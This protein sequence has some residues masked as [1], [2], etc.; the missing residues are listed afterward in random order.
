LDNESIDE[1][2]FLKRTNSL[3]LTV[4]LRYK[5]HIE[6]NEALYV[7]DLPRLVDPGNA[8]V[9]AL[10]ARIKESFELYDYDQ[11]FMDAAEYAYKY[12][13][14]EVPSVSLPIQFWQRSNETIENRVG[15]VFDKSVLLCSVLSALGC[16]SANVVLS[17]N[18]GREV[19]VCFEAGSRILAYRFDEDKPHEFGSRDEM[20]AWIQKGDDAQV[21]MFN[22][23]SCVDL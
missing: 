9:T 14:R 21:Y 15:D 20:R 1:K 10:A 8:A 6:K 4:I 2:E 16:A 19:A 5:D 13:R 18:E 7:P 12:I 17:L 23:I 11:N 22:N 3:Y